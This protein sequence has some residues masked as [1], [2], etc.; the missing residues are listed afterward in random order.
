MLISFLGRVCPTQLCY[1]I[2]RQL[3]HFDVFP[4]SFP[5]SVCTLSA[6]Q[7]SANVVPPQLRNVVGMYLSKP[8]LCATW[9]YRN[10]RLSL[11]EYDLSQTATALGQLS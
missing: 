9:F 7:N 11:L 10:K 8:N 5:R 4:A 6:L 1:H 2:V 3:K